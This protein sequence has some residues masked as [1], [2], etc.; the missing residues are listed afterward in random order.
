MW[1]KGH[2]RHDRVAHV[3]FRCFPNSLPPT[4]GPSRSPFFRVIVYFVGCLY[5]PSGTVSSY[6]FGI[7]FRRFGW[8]RFCLRCLLRLPRVTQEG[9]LFPITFYGTRKASTNEL[10]RT[11]VRLGS[12]STAQTVT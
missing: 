3:L 4:V 10:I 12:S 1:P 9:S 6:L 11:L 5:G 7:S 2:P 8:G